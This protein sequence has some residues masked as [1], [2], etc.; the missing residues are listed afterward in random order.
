MSMIKKLEEMTSLLEEAVGATT[1]GQG[2]E[3]VHP[4]DVFYDLGAI[5]EMARLS[6]VDPDRANEA[7]EAWSGWASSSTLHTTWKSGDEEALRAFAALAAEVAPVAHVL[8]GQSELYVLVN[9]LHHL[10]NTL[11]MHNDRGTYEKA[12]VALADLA[13]ARRESGN[14]DLYLARL[15]LDVL[16]DRPG[17]AGEPADD[18]GS[19]MVISCEIPRGTSLG[20]IVEAFIRAA[21]STVAEVYG[22]AVEQEG[23]PT[24]ELLW[25]ENCLL[26]AWRRIAARDST[27]QQ[28]EDG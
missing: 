28:G 15:S 3:L 21:F 16:G 26:A 10:G 5:L 1:A 17:M 12:W 25:A 4:R 7:L 6:D 8:D 2:F 20:E 19:G 18:G 9:P 11:L 27:S 24:M 22:K 14:S 23:S 13:E